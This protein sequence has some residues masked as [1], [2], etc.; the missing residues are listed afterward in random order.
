[1]T[2]HDKR[3]K[4]RFDS[5][6]LLFYVCLDE[7]DQVLTQGMGRTLNVSEGGILLETHVSLDQEHIVSL[8]ISMENEIID[9]KG[10]ISFQQ[11]RGDGMFESGIQFIEPDEKQQ[12][13]IKQYIILF[14]EEME[15]LSESET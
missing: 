12:Q 14:R 6:N 7:N 15:K 10:N 13:I 11:K 3:K 2:T 4:P 5:H 1:M 8:T 9:I